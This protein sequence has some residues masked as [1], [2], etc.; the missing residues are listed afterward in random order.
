MQRGSVN[1]AVFV[2]STRF[3]LDQAHLQEF[4][5]CHCCEQDQQPIFCFAFNLAP[6]SRTVI[7]D[8]ECVCAIKQCAAIACIDDSEAPMLDDDIAAWDEFKSMRRMIELTG[9]CH[10]GHSLLA[11]MT[12]RSFNRQAPGL[13]FSHCPPR[14]A[15]LRMHSTCRESTPCKWNADHAPS[16]TGRPRCDSNCGACWSC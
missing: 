1:Q 11:L 6:L 16:C 9:A 15:T 4:T 13:F 5:R 14:P 7:N 8:E 12:S 3:Y 10:L 2:M